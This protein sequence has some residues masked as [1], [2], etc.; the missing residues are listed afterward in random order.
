MAQQHASMFNSAFWK[1]EV[2]W[3]LHPIL[4]CGGDIERIDAVRF[5]A[6]G[7]DRSIF[8]STLLN[9]Y[10][11]QNKA[12]GH[13][14]FLCILCLHDTRAQY[15]ALSKGFTCCS[16]Y[17]RQWCSRVHSVWVQVHWVQVKVLSHEGSSSMSSMRQNVRK[18]PY[19]QSDHA[20]KNN[21]T[22]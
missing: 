2:Y 9:E 8:F 3:R 16:W 14:G 21:N 13:M 10:P 15:L 20:A 12:Q 18:I 7:S 5:T 1:F 11:A 17:P 22:L 6:H 4:S 19:S